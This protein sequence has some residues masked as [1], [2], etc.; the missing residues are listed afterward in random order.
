MAL[1]GSSGK[2]RTPWAHRELQ[3]GSSLSLLSCSMCEGLKSSQSSHDLDLDLKY[4]CIPF[5]PPRD[6]CI[7]DLRRKY[8]ASVKIVIN[9]NPAALHV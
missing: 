7:H 3:N 4:T 5:Y 1:K 2:Q 6:L 8:A 9:V